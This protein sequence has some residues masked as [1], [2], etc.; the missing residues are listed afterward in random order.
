MI[1]NTAKN[2]A[3]NEMNMDMDKCFEYKHASLNKQN[4]KITGA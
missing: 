1:I 3:C 4:F 2:L